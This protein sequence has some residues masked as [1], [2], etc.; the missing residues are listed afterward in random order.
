MSC[1]ANHRM[2]TARSAAES[3]RFPC[4]SYQGP[5]SP[6]LY[7][8]LAGRCPYFRDRPDADNAPLSGGNVQIAEI[9]VI[10]RRAL[11]ALAEAAETLSPSERAPPWATPRTGGEAVRPVPRLVFGHRRRCDAKGSRATARPGPAWRGRA[12]ALLPC[13]L[14]TNMWMTCAQRRRSCVCA[15]EMLGI[16]LP[17]RT[18]DSAFTWESAT[19]S[20]CIRES[21]NFPHATP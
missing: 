16:P 5:T 11:R 4:S 1:P 7:T 8:K 9:P 3:G 14:C 20:L 12:R 6:R 13:W 19:R 21:W 10:E 18:H 2:L 15:V 17:G